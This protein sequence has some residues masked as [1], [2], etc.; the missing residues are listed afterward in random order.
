[1]TG[2]SEQFPGG[3]KFSDAR[4]YILKRRDSWLVLLSCPQNLFVIKNNNSTL[5]ILLYDG[6]KTESIC[7]QMPG[8]L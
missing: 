6:V 7:L 1:M 4:E 8:N 3:R 2:L 5:L